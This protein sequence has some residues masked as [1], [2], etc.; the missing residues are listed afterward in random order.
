MIAEGR[1][2]DSSVPTGDVFLPGWRRV[3]LAARCRIRRDLT[4]TAAIDNLFGSR[5]EEV[6][7]APSP[8]VRLR[9]GIEAKF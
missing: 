4:V 9:G 1:V 6:I 3:D 7:G 5:Y 2:F 8:G